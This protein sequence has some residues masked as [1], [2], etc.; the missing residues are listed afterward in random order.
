MFNGDV[1]VIYSTYLDK[2]H[3]ARQILRANLTDAKGI[4]T[5]TLS[6]PTEL[7]EQHG[8]KISPGKA[9]S[10]TNFKVLP[11]TNYDRS[12]CDWILLLTELSTVQN[13][14][15]ICKDYKFIPDTTVK[16]LT[17]NT[18]T[19]PIGTIAAVVTVA[20]KVGFQYTLQ[21]KDGNFDDNRSTVT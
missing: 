18:E 5:I 16:Q 14:P 11:K 19:Y 10:I 7:I 12:D 13:I 15:P 20:R 3:K 8:Q 9:I 17:T 6:I 21:I 4:M 2:V 1:M